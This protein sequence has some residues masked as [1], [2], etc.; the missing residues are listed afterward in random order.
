MNLNTRISEEELKAIE[1][2]ID[3]LAPV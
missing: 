1:E 2:R 3:K